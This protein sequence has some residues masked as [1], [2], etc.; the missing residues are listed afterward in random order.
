MKLNL[1]FK[2][3]R[4]CVCLLLLLL[5][6]FRML[7]VILFYILSFKRPKLCNRSKYNTYLYEF[8]F[9]RKGPK[10]L[11]QLYTSHETLYIFDFLPHKE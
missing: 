8:F 4:Y 6:L 9:F 7:S 5:L 11:L 10:H 3:V 1:N 2:L